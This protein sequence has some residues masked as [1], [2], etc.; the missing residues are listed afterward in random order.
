MSAPRIHGCLAK[1][2]IS[3]PYQ[4]PPDTGQL[5]YSA[6]E[7]ES[8]TSISVITMTKTSL[9]MADTLLAV[10]CAVPTHGRRATVQIQFNF[11]ELLL[12]SYVLASHYDF[13]DSW[14][15]LDQNIFNY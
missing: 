3:A 5:L 12:Q 4:F 2:F 14:Y 1:G 11:S 9:R 6:G 13:F 7:A 10:C 15:S 8:R